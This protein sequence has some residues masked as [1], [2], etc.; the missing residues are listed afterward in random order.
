MRN[1]IS[2]FSSIVFVSWQH[3]RFTHPSPNIANILKALCTVEFLQFLRSPHV[4]RHKEVSKSS[5]SVRICMVFFPEAI[6]SSEAHFIK[7]ATT[8]YKTTGIGG[9]GQLLFNKNTKCPIDAHCHRH[10]RRDPRITKD[11]IKV[12]SFGVFLDFCK[13]FELYWFELGWISMVLSLRFEILLFWAWRPRQSLRRIWVQLFAKA[14]E[15]SEA[16]N[17]NAIFC[18]PW[19]SSA[20]AMAMS[21]YRTLCVLVSSKSHS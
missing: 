16:Q 7:F 21:I 8:L 1:W 6:K 13:K 14:K 12:F 4:L 15:N 10:C 2:S 18:N 17:F 11:C 19:I 20:M 5:K 3:Y 9:G